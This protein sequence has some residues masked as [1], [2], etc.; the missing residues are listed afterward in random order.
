LASTGVRVPPG[1]FLPP[2]PRVE[3]PYRLTPK[4]ALRVGILGAVALAAFAVLFLR[5][6]ALQVLSSAQYLNAAQNNQLRTIRLEAPRG[7]VLDRNGHVLVENVPG[8]AVRVWPSDLPKKGR[9][10]ELRRLAGI[11]H[12]PLA[13]ITADVEK[14]KG[15]PVTPVTVKARASEPEAQYLYERQDEFPGVEIASAFLRD[16][17]QGVLAAHLLGYVGE[18]S[19]EQLKRRPKA[20]YRAGDR[21]GQAGIEAAYDGYL[22]GRPGLAQ[23]RVDSLGHPRSD[24]ERSQL[25]QPGNSIRLTLD[26]R[27]QRTAEQALREWVANARAQSDCFGCWAANGGAIVAL[28]PR[29]GAVRAMASYPTYNPAV[30]VGRVDERKLAAFGLTR[31]TG[32]ARN[33]PALNRAT[34]GGYPA[35]STWKPVTALAAM[36]EHLISPYSSLTCD[37]QYEAYGQTFHN[38]NPDIYTS[39]TLPDAL[40][41]SCDTYFYRIGRIFYEL[42]PEYGPALQKWAARFG[43]GRATGI[44]IGGEN[45]GLL[46]TPAWRKATFEDEVERSWKPGDSIQ[47]AIGQKDLQ[48]TPLQMARFYALIANG[49]RLVTPHLGMDVEEPGNGKT[50]AVVLRQ[51]T[52][53]RSQP[54][55]VDPAALQAVRDGLFQATHGAAGTSTAVFGN[56]PVDIAGKTG[57][58]ERAVRLPGWTGT[59][60]VD[61]AWWCG[62]GPV[63]DPELV[64]CALIENGGHGGFVA[65]PAAL[66]V[67]ETYFG[68]KA[69]YQ[70][71]EATD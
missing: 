2:D 3:E 20:G 31:G 54:T 27:V 61:Q 34:M 39:M 12:V 52:P 40:E 59:D 33:Y 66:R 69:S 43:F 64:V 10:Q 68:V 11:L 6:W 13:R 36:E 50:D 17:P 5:L 37:G 4:L 38:W 56:F 67:F 15:D 60:L 53:R 35:G 8:T 21:I 29:D 32:P 7:S 45:P 58:A 19:K 44:E 25:P 22:R 9:Y 49:G 57:T 41:A 70:L 1:R 14:R 46:P 71:P 30:F 48:V 24:L 51:F 42:P 63:G 65:A 23:L 47:L 26:V 55:G 18:V 16:Y 28:D 62:Y